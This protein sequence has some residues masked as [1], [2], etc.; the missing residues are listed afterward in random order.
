MYGVGYR[1]WLLGRYLEKC[2]C[3]EDKGSDTVY[4]PTGL[5]TVTKTDRVMPGRVS[6][7]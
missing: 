3:T 2:P 4:V 1:L 6:V 7:T 5:L